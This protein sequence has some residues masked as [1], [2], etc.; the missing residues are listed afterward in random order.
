MVLAGCAQGETHISH[1]AR[2][3]YKESD[4]I[5]A[6][7]QELEA[8]GV[9][10]RAEEDDISCRGEGCG[11]ASGSFGRIRITASL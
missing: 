2:L 6:M 8:F 9:S 7:Q 4:R 1:V 10:M 3:R 11:P 5:A